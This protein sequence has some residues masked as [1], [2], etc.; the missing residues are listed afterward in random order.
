MKIKIA[1]YK[2]YILTIF[3]LSTEMNIKSQAENSDK[4]YAVTRCLGNEE[5]FYHL[6]KISG[7]H[8]QLNQILIN[9]FAD[10]TGVTFRPEIL[11]KLCVAPYDK[12]ISRN[13]WDA[14]FRLNDHGILE[15]DPK[16]DTAK[17]LKKDFISKLPALFDQYILILGNTAPRAN[18]MLDLIP[19]LK[20]IQ[21][22]RKYLGDKVP[23]FDQ[24]RKNGVL[25]RALD[26][27][28]KI[29]KLWKDCPE[30]KSIQN[31]APKT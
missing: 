6:N 22:E 27:L 20:E 12:K 14:L 30:P 7:P 8:Y 11:K 26:K 2:Y 13:L 29:P 25:T 21:E 15:V 23:F 5:R 19:E 24:A 10:L 17:K 28:Q 3:F 16:S 31:K 9:E 4:T 1:K 18:C